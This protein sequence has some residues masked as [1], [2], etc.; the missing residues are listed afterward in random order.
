MY[1]RTFIISTI[2]SAA[3]LAGI[4][5]IGTGCSPQS[6]RRVLVSAARDTQGK[7]SIRLNDPLSDHSTIIPVPSR[8]HDACHR[9]GYS[10]IVAFERRPGYQF[11][12]V[13]LREEKLASTVPVAN[14]RH[15]YGH[16]VFS[17]DGRFLYTTENDTTTLNG[18]IGIYDAEQHYQR[19][20]EWPLLLP[21]PHELKLMP[22]GETLVIA[23]GGIQTHPDTGR[24]TLNPQTLQPALVY[25]D[26]RSGKVINQQHFIDPRLSI[27]HL[28]V[29]PDGLVAIGMQYQGTNDEA[30]PLVA[31]H[32]VGQPIRAVEA[33][34]EQWMAL[35]G[36]IA[37]VE[38]LP[39]MDTLAV[40]SPR[41]NRIAF[42]QQSTGR[43][44]TFIYQ[45]DCAGIAAISKSQLAVS[46]G[47]GQVQILECFEGRA[48]TIKKVIHS[49]CQWDN[50]MLMV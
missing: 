21:G 6:D 33:L 7:F 35:N 12:V 22:D 10:E 3:V 41:G 47:Q 15:L 32:R 5:L 2:K 37:S 11:H 23:V 13:D 27:R 16:G 9:P 14:Q 20:G 25:L 29:A 36:Y 1:R 38:V 34:P 4:S 31:T 49:Q 45:R 26:R 44:Q 39:D 46:D 48:T 19:V 30:L 40:T 50:H 28:D 8:L 43:L 24:T 42:I 18:V 17:H